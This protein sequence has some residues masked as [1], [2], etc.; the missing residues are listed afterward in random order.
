MLSGLRSYWSL[1][2]GHLHSSHS[3]G[4]PL[5]SN[6]SSLFSIQHRWVL[7]SQWQVSG[8]IN[9]DQQTTTSIFSN[10]WKRV[11]NSIY[12]VRVCWQACAQARV[13]VGILL[14]TPVKRIKIQLHTSSFVLK[15]TLSFHLNPV[16]YLHCCRAPFCLCSTSFWMR[17]CG[18]CLKQK[19]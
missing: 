18:Q 15:F 14:P 7:S 5:S 6:G 16:P 12:Y 13:C 1:V 19:R 17:R 11:P 3:N 10:I 2:P 9:I 4:E 8:N